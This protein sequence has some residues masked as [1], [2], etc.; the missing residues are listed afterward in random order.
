M[1][2]FDLLVIGDI[3]LGIPIAL[4]SSDFCKTRGRISCMQK[5]V[6]LHHLPLLPRQ[7]SLYEIQL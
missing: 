1:V 4:I 6:F 7:V 3:D 5:N 2:S